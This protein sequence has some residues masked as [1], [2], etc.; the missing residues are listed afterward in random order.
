MDWL[1]AG[2][3]ASTAVFKISLTSVP[4]SNPLAVKNSAHPPVFSFT[5]NLLDSI[6]EAIRARGGLSGVL[7][8]QCGTLVAP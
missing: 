4:I 7:T 6:I 8:R 3:D 5:L 2:L 1:E